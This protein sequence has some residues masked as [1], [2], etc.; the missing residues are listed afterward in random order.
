MINRVRA[1]ISTGVNAPVESHGAIT[2]AYGRVIAVGLASI[3]DPNNAHVRLIMSYLQD[4]ELGR[5]RISIYEPAV[6]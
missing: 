4:A 6:A 2:V 1:V 3:S 5:D